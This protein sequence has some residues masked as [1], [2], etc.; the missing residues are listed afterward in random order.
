MVTVSSDAIALITGRTAA[1][2]ARPPSQLTGL[3]F[4]W[5]SSPEGT[6]PGPLPAVKER[7]CQPVVTDPGGA[8]VALRRQRGTQATA[9]DDGAHP[10]RTRR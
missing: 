2:G 10:G 3:G 7:T 9:S 4:A 1:L 5:R 6:R 8:A